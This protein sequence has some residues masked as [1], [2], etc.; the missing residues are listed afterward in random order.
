MFLRIVASQELANPL[1]I[2]V[3]TKQDG[4]HP[5]HC[6]LCGNKASLRRSFTKPVVYVLEQ[7]VMVTEGRKGGQTCRR[8]QSGK[9][10]AQRS[11]G[12]AI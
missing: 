7:H 11:F 1:E 12:H 4:Q 3:T 5:A 6:R 2:T 10:Q 9:R 8:R